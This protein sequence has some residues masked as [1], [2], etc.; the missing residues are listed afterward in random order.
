M[1]REDQRGLDA[2]RL[3]TFGGSAEAYLV[4]EVDLSKGSASGD[5][6]GSLG[7]MPYAIDLPIVLDL[8][9]HHNLVRH[10]LIV[11]ADRL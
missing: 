7:M 1:A 10:T 9:L 3:D 2:D 4:E 8:M 5:E 6:I 11:F